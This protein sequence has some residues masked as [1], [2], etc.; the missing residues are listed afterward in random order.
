MSVHTLQIN[1]TRGEITPLMQGRIDTDFYQSAWARA[2]NV[3]ISR[4]GSMLR[5]PGTLHRGLTRYAGRRTKMLTFE[6]NEEQVYSMEFGHLY[7]RFWTR[8]GPIVTA[9]GAP[10]QIGTPYAEADLKN[11]KIAQSGDAVYIFCRG[12]QPRILRRFG[13]LDWRMSLYTPKDGPYMP[14][15]VTEAWVALD[16][17]GHVNTTMTGP[18]T[19]GFAASG[20]TG[21]AWQVFNRRKD[22]SITVA[23][24]ETGFVQ[25]DMTAANGP[26]VVNSYWITAGSKNAETD[27]M[28][29]QWELRASNNGTDWITLDSRDGEAGWD[30]SETRYFEFPNKT[31]WRFYRLNFS[32][33]SGFDPEHNTTEMAQ[34]ALG[35]EAADQS[36]AT[37]Y[38]S[39]PA[40]INNGRGFLPSDVRRPVRVQGAD[41]R[42]RWLE[43]SAYLNAQEVRVKI[44]GFAFPDLSMMNAF[45]IGAWSDTSGWP[46]TGRFFEDRLTTVS[47]DDDPLGMWMSITGGYDSYRVSQPVVDDDAISIRLSGGTFSRVQWLA[48]VG[49]LLAGTGATLRSVGSRD[50]GGVLSPSNIRQRAETTTAASSV[51]PIEVE[52]VVLF[53][54]RFKK[55]L[56]E[57]AFTYEADGYLTREISILNEHLFGVGIERIEWLDTPHKIAVC[58]RTDGKLVFFSYDR[59]QKVAGATLVD[60]GARVEDICAM[61]GP[62]GT[63]LFITVWRDE[64]LARQRQVEILAPFWRAGE[65]KLPVYSASSVTRRYARPAATCDGL[66]HLNG[67]TVGVWADGRDMGDYVVSGGRITLPQYSAA[68]DFVVGLRLPWGLKTLRV[69]NYGQQDGT[70]LGR[71]MKILNARVD[72]FESA[73]V[74]MGTRPDDMVEIRFENDIEENPDDPKTL[75]TGMT[76]IN[77]VDDSWFNEGVFDIGGDRMYPVTIRGLSLQVEGEP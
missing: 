16:R 67:K 1:G 12:Y 60:L 70:G 68:R 72:L 23:N 58:L 29:T 71:K 75:H 56:F 69:T 8:D 38:L 7:V 31:A 26:R 19:A 21:N 55:R 13:E 59:E 50:S 25:M 76:P 24:G 28:F 6:F 44:H 62:E 36:S 52:T 18:S 33:G 63:D 47:T 54:D 49:T 4:Y 61:P 10:Y 11:I 57:A 48:E 15:N 32:G 40:V 27:S 3:V 37:L 77:P 65:D 35:W 39:D 20:S 41:N 64:P 53:I 46:I 43:I 34:L 66:A 14:I 30:G 73:G 22:Q 9:P 42:W 45:R 2:R 74:Y 17:T 5:V 51:D